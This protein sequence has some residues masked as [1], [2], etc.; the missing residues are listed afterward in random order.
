MRPVRSV[1][2]NVQLP[3]EITAC[4]HAVPT[5]RAK[6]LALFLRFFYNA[7]V[8]LNGVT[9]KSDSSLPETLPAEF[10]QE[11]SL[12]LLEPWFSDIN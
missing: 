12:T 8:P 6:S 3:V 1:A 9:H 2:W 11:L 10:K 7:N 4:F 5:L